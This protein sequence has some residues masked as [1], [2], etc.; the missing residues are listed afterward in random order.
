MPWRRYRSSRTDTV[1]LFWCLGAFNP[2]S[3]SSVH[4]APKLL[5]MIKGRVLDRKKCEKKMETGHQNSSGLLLEA[6]LSLPCPDPGDGWPGRCSAPSHWHISHLSTFLPVLPF[7][8]HP[9]LMTRP[10]NSMAWGILVS[11][12]KGWDV[13][14]PCGERAR[15]G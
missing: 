12:A 1:G 8:C 9:R 3:S 7:R 6:N 11:S 10:M 2:I 14:Q 5:Q 15:Q 4:G 13:G